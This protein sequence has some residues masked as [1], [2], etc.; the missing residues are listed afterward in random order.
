MTSVGADGHYQN[1]KGLPC[2]T[3][4]KGIRI[5]DVSHFAS[6]LVEHVTVSPPPFGRRHYLH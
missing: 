4:P 5:D 3:I 6:Q 2:S 1:K